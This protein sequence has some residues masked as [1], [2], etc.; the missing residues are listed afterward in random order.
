MVFEY[1]DHDLTGILSQTEFKFTAAHLKSLHVS[2]LKW[3][4]PGPVVDV[5]NLAQATIKIDIYLDVNKGRLINEGSKVIFVSAYL[6][7]QT[8]DWLEPYIR[9]YYEKANDE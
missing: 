6:R 2:M 3:P 8:W 1:M 9:E 7:G 4:I 5:S